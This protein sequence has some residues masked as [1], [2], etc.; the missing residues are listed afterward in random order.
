MSNTRSGTATLDGRWERHLDGVNGIGLLDAL[1]AVLDRLAAEPLTAAVDDDALTASIQRLHRSGIRV[2]AEK[3]RRTAEADERRGWTGKGASVLE[4]L[5]GDLGLSGREAREQ[6]ETAALLPRLPA[7][8]RQFSEG[9]LGNGQLREAARTVKELDR[10][11]ERSDVPLDRPAPVEELVGQLDELVAEQGGTADHRTLRRALDEWSA[12]TGT[13]LLRD[14]QRRARRNR[15]LWY[16]KADPDGMLRIEGQLD[17]LAGAH[18]MAA[19]DA[20]SRPMDSDDPR[21]IRQRRADALV[22]LCQRYLDEGTLPQVANR[23]PH[24]IIVGTP[25]SFAALPGSPG[26]WLDGF[27]TVG[28]DVARQLLCDAEVSLVVMGHDGAPLDVGR[29]RRDPTP[30]QRTAVTARDRCCVGCGAPVARC[31]IHHVRWWRDGGA[32]DISNLV[33]V[34]WECHHRLHHDGWTVTRD[35]TGR[36]RAGPPP[37]RSRTG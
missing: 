6:A 2:E 28:S 15:R 11:A 27:G 16:G 36:Y 8:A 10:L 34:C 18:V 29:T 35:G 30:R 17:P 31:Q 37:P 9:Q 1:D 26:A 13:D 19:L 12:E 32:T 5:A 4:I 25:E 23:R 3:L 7:T 22:E 14:R 21:D 20:L 33:L 24:A